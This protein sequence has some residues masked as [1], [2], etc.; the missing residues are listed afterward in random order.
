MILADALDEVKA[1]RPDSAFSDDQICD[2]IRAC[3]NTVYREILRDESPPLGTGNEL[4]VP[5]PY[6]RMYALYA[7]GM[8]ELY[9]GE[10]AKYNNT[11]TAYNELY[12]GFAAWYIRNNR[13]AESMVKIW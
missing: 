7:I 6:S 11:M 12:Y 8:M 4:I 9:L 10:Y 5:E 3:E 13:P 2:F 1:F